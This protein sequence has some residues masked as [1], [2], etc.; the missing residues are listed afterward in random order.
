MTEEL[1]HM[2]KNDHDSVKELLKEATEKEEL[3]RFREIKD[4]LNTHMESE[5]KYFYP[6]IKA[7]DEVKVNQSFREHEEAREL[8]NDIEKIPWQDNKRLSKLNEL[9]ESVENHVEKE[10]EII[11]PESSERLSTLQRE[12]IAQKIEEEKIS[13]RSKSIPHEKFVH[14]P[15][16][17]EVPQTIPSSKVRIP[18]T[19]AEGEVEYEDDEGNKVDAKNATH[20]RLTGMDRRTDIV[21]GPVNP[22]GMIKLT[23]YFDDENSPTAKEKSTNSKSKIL[24]EEY[25]P[26]K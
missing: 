13:K 10:E 24:N 17:I 12:E 8:I 6:R 25:R 14:L 26:L 4:K 22:E 5:E 20:I 18:S 9:R 23:L 7:I 15:E 11:F 3:S 19:Y 21:I 1:Y 16:N 2:L